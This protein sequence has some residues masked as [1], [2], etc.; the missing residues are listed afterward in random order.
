L[1]F[2][3]GAADSPAGAGDDRNVADEFHASLS[4]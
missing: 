4:F 3:D 1:R 2:C